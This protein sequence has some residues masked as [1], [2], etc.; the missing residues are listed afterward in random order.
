MAVQRPPDE[1]RGALV[2]EA[3]AQRN[4]KRYEV[5]IPDKALSSNGHSKPLYHLLAQS[6]ASDI[7][8]GA[9]AVGSTLPSEKSLTSIHGVSRQTVRQALALLRSQGLI[10]SRPGVGSIVLPAPQG[11]EA[12]APITSAEDLRDFLGKTELHQVSLGPITVNERLSEVLECRRG[13]QLSEACFLRRRPQ[14]PLPMSVLR[15]YLPPQYAAAQITPDVARGPIYQNLER[16]FGIAVTEVRQDV[17]ATVLDQ[18]TARL[19]QAAPGD[20]ALQVVR[21][22]YSATGKPVEVTV[23]HYPSSRYRQSVRYALPP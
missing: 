14:A 18:D 5:T 19:L 7:E 11:A 6:L 17:T 1:I 3:C 20:P 23:G 9:F 8:S 15:I 12:F 13:I 4:G 10:A 22:Y 2:S 21:F 16:M